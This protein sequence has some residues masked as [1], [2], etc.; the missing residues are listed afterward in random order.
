MRSRITVLS[1]GLVCLIGLLLTAPT[2]NAEVIYHDGQIVDIYGQPMETAP[3]SR[4]LSEQALEASAFE[5]SHRLEGSALW[6]GTLSIAGD[7]NY[8]YVAKYFGIE[9]YDI[10]VPSAPVKVGQYF[11]LGSVGEMV[12]DGGFLYVAAAGDGTLVFDVTDPNAPVLVSTI[13]GEGF[14]SYGFYF[15]ATGI[16]IVGTLIYIASDNSFIIADISD[17]AAPVIVSEVK[18]PA[19]GRKVTVQ[20]NF[21]YLAA[22][23]RLEV[24]DVSDASNPVLDYSSSVPDE[25]WDVV[26]YGDYLFV[27]SRWSGVYSFD[28]TASPS[29]PIMSAYIDSNAVW[30]GVDVVGDKLYLGGGNAK[31]VD[32]ELDERVQIVSNKNG[33]RGAAALWRD[34]F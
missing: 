32:I 28:L 9:V 3:D 26:D 33:I 7:E 14:S 24:W 30:F 15:N 16:D 31:K 2:S 17:P 29:L 27:S 11:R 4:T 6:Q 18:S 34:K 12:L 19:G 10:S 21:A 22:D 1:V 23:S 8:S 13:R 5:L 25:S 20:G